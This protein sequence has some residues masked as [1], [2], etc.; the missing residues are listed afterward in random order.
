MEINPRGQAGKMAAGVSFLQ[1]DAPNVVVETVKQAEDGKGWIVRRYECSK[2]QTTA[3]LSFGIA[4]TQVQEV[5]LME[6]PLGALALQDGQ[7]T[8][9]FAPFE[10]KSLRVA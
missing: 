4:A 3:R 1:V 10:I 5:D 8:L 7:V 6:A 9:A 2:A